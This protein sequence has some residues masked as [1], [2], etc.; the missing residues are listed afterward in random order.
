MS[1]EDTWYNITYWCSNLLYSVYSILYLLYLAFTI[2][3]TS[4]F[5][6]R[7]FSSLIYQGTASSIAA[8]KKN[9]VAGTISLPGRELIIAK[10]QYSLYA[11]ISSLVFTSVQPI[12][13]R[14]TNTE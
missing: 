9:I 12:L 14:M 8:H 10:E 11:R 5:D 1:K 4:I 3:T 13:G 2:T 6:F 7:A